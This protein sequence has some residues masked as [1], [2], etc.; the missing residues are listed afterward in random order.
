M[1]T[2]SVH[3]VYLIRRTFDQLNVNRF[4]CSKVSRSIGV[5]QIIMFASAVMTN[6]KQSI[7]VGSEQYEG[8]I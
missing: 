6:P 8:M 3:F 7:R 1:A 4:I 2:Y 5:L